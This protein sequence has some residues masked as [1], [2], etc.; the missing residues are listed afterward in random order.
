MRSP[1][2]PGERYAI[3]MCEGQCLNIHGE[4]EDEPLPSD[5]DDAFYKRCRFT[6]FEAACQAAERKYW[7]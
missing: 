1:F 3:R 4:W 7:S 5:R 2:Y 6:T